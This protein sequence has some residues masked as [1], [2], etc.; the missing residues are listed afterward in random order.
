[1]QFIFY[2]IC[3]LS[4]MLST[5]GILLFSLKIAEFNVSYEGHLVAHI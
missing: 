2:R 4:I 5:S 1:M 3:G